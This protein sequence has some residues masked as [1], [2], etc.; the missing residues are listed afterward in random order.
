[1]A[2]ATVVIAVFT[3]KL[4][5]A[6]DLLAAADNAQIRLSNLTFSRW[7]GDDEIPTSSRS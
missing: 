3:A 4:K 2:L 1:M 6:T 7:G 5:R